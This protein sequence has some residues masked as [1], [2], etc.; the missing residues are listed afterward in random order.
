MLDPKGE[1]KLSEKRTKVYFFS[2]FLFLA[3]AIIAFLLTRIDLFVAYTS[4]FNGG[5]I[6]CGGVGF[7]QIGFYLYS[8]KMYLE[9]KGRKG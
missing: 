9:L 5:T 6:I 3:L 8:R 7:V 4:F 1:L 2:I